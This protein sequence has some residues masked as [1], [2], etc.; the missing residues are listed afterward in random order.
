[1]GNGNNKFKKIVKTGIFITGCCYAFN[2]YVSSR[3]LLKNILNKA[4]GKKY[5][6]KYGNIYYE[7]MNGRLWFR[8]S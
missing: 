8:N 3:A 5:E 4:N 2:K 7:V 1:M 6:W